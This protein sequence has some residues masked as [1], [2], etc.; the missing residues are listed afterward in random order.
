MGARIDVPQIGMPRRL[1]SL[2]VPAAL[3]VLLLLL[4]QWWA[5]SLPEG[6]PAPAPAKVVQAFVVLLSS[7]ELAAATLQSLGRVMG[8]FALASA[9]GITLGV[10][11][12]THRGLR[13]NLDP[14]V[15]LFRPIAPMAI[16]PIAILWF[17]T[18]TSTALAIVTY[19]TFFPVLVNTVYGVSRVDRRLVQAA[20]TMGVGPVT[21]L[22]RVLLPAALPS[23]LVGLRLG[24]GVA[25]TAIIAAELAVGAKSGGGSSGGIGQMMFVFYAY[26]VDLNAI[27]VCMLVVGVVFLLLDLV[28]RWIEKRLISWSV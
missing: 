16:L 19:A 20:R 27:V 18:G 5:S 4:W 11:M 12:G 23:I 2:A 28:A 15:E 10:L 8:G 25:W 1:A 17:G 7:G 14:I 26:S 9:L 13:E 21:I 6:S 24:M 22:L 3:P